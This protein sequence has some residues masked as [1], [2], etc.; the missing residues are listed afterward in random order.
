MESILSM[1][2]ITSSAFKKED[3]LKGG[4]GGETEKEKE[5]YLV[6]MKI[7]AQSMNGAQNTGHTLSTAIDPSM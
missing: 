6:T 7:K 2:Q 4:G 5:K 3:H 1:P